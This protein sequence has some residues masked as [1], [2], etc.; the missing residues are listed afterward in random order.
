MFGVQFYNISEELI[1]CRVSQQSAQSH[2][3]PIVVP[4]V[5]VVVLANVAVTR[6]GPI[7]PVDHGPIIPLMTVVVLASDPVAGIRPVVPVDLGPI[8][9]AF[10]PSAALNT[11][12][13][14][15][16]VA[17]LPACDAAVAVPARVLIT[18]VVPGVVI[19][20]PAFMSAAVATNT[21]IA[22]DVLPV[23]CASEALVFDRRTNSKC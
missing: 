12:A 5:T 16:V 7:V 18:P 17:V 13:G 8:V 11:I 22:G 6:V 9:P 15:A 21:L 1:C 14:V 23:R 3:V 2:S 20:I 19:V 10:A 4:L